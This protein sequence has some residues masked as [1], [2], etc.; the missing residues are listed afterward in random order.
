MADL[1]SR[2]RNGPA[3]S[4]TVGGGGR[5]RT[6]RQFG[7]PRHHPDTPPRVGIAA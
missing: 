6:P 4:G 5:R 2:C 7:R 3:G 1:P